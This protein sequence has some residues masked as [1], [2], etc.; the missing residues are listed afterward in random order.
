MRIAL[1]VDVLRIRPRTPSLSLSLLALLRLWR[2]RLRE[3]RELLLMSERELR[4]LAITRADVQREVAKPF[5][6]A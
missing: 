2:S 6:K 4:D 3:R 5:W 1:G